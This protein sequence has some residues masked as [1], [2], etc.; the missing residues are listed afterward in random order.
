MEEK[1]RELEKRV[2]EL[3]VKAQNQPLL[4]KLDITNN[5]D[6]ADYLFKCIVQYQQIM[7]QSNYYQ[8]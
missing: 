5:S 3:E 8:E 2:A 7:T 6:F 1:I 4:I